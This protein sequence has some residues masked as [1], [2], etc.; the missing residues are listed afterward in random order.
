MCLYWLLAKYLDEC[1]VLRSSMFYFLSPAIFIFFDNVFSTVI[2]IIF[3]L[4]LPC[5]TNSIYTERGVGVFYLFFQDAFKATEPLEATDLTWVEMVIG[6]LSLMVYLLAI[7]ERVFGRLIL[8]VLLLLPSNPHFFDIIFFTTA[9]IT[10][11]LYLPGLINSIC[12][13]KRVKVFCLF[14]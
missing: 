6:Y 5:L 14:F 11:I 4:Y 12:I 1:L 8:E 10:F 7:A 9:V 3:T 13:E 2:A